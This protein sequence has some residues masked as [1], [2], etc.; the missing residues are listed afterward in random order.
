MPGKRLSAAK[1]RCPQ[2]HRRD[3][4][5]VPKACGPCGQR[6][7]RRPEDLTFETVA[8]PKLRL[9]HPRMTVFGKVARLKPRRNKENS[10]RNSTSPITIFGKAPKEAAGPI[11]Q[12]TPSWAARIATRSCVWGCVSAG[13]NASPH[14]SNLSPRS[15]FQLWRSSLTMPKTLCPGPGDRVG[16]PADTL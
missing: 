14:C 7:P 15:P 10:R 3:T 12:A 11:S 9:A 1:P 4:A 2:V 16:Q 5:S 13:A 8:L 6:G